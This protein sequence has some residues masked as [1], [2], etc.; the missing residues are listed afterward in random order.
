[1]P[2]RKALVTGSNRGLGFATARQL[3]HLGL[4]VVVT[5]RDAEKADAAAERLRGEAIRVVAHQ[6]DVASE[7]SFARLAAL[8]PID[9]LVNNAAD[10]RRPH[11]PRTVRGVGR[12]KR[13][14]PP[15]G[16]S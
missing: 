11:V 3:G 2:I 1:M 10:G 12:G 9:V 5:A 13:T 4:Q 16:R 15:N 6:L 8:G 7:E 14:S